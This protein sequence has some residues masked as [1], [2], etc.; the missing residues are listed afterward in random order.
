MG[1]WRGQGTCPK[2][3]GSHH[4]SDSESGLFPVSVDPTITSTKGAILVELDLTPWFR[5]KITSTLRGP[6]EP[7]AAL[8]G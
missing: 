7:S 5:D 3:L 6:S 1:Y 8:L 2:L 4:I